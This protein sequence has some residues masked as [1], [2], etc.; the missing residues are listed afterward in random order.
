MRLQQSDLDRVDPGNVFTILVCVADRSILEPAHPKDK[1]FGCAMPSVHRCSPLNWL[2][3][4]GYIYS[5]GTRFTSHIQELY[6]P[7][8]I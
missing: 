5:N 2:H 1:V 8:S 3:S 4:V 6:F 7:E